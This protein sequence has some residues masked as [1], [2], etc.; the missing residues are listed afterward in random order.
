MMCF[1][2][3]SWVAASAAST[4]SSFSRRRASRFAATAGFCHN[5]CALRMR[6]S[7]PFGSFKYAR[8]ISTSGRLSFAP[9]TGTRT[10][11]TTLSPRGGV[12]VTLSGSDT[13]G[14]D[15]WSRSIRGT[16][17]SDQ[18]HTTLTI[19]PAYRKLGSFLFEPTRYQRA[20]E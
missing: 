17:R 1:R 7:R 16:Q 20:Q 3:R 2:S 13:P 18:I 11:R 19:A 8:T 4:D 9:D 6:P 14:Y 10:C 15:H 12:Q 5:M